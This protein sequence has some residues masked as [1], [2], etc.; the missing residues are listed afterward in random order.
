MDKIWTNRLIAGTKFWSDVPEKRRAGVTEELIAR[1]ASG[2]IT[3]AQMNDI[4]GR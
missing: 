2:E 1:V 4:L 3:E